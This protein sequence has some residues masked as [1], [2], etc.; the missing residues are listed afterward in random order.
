MTSRDEVLERIAPIHEHV[1]FVRY[2]PL[3]EMVLTWTT[4]VL[5]V[6]KTLCLKF[7]LSSNDAKTTTA[8][9]DSLSIPKDINIQLS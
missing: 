6:S 5:M 1:K 4:Q 9:R 3:K 2:I 8:V 7:V